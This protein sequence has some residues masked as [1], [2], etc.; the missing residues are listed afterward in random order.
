MAAGRLDFGIQTNLGNVA[1]PVLAQ[2]AATK[3]YVDTRGGGGAI[4][5]DNLAPI[6]INGNNITNNAIINSNTNTFFMTCT[7][8]AAAAAAYLNDPIHAGVTEYYFTGSTIRFNISSAA[9]ST[10]PNII[11]V[12]LNSFTDFSAAPVAAN[13]ALI[14]FSNAYTQINDIAL[15]T[16]LTGAVTNNAAG[17]PTLTINATGSAAITSPNSTITVGGT[18]TAP[19]IDVNIPAETTRVDNEIAARIGSAT[20]R[21]QM[22]NGTQ[23]LTVIISQIPGLPVTMTISTLTNAAT[24]LATLTSLGANARTLGSSQTGGATLLVESY[25]SATFQI[26]ANFPPATT[27]AQ[28]QNAF[29][30]VRSDSVWYGGPTTGQFTFQPAPKQAIAN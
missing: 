30:G 18:A 15:G 20:L 11:E 8:N 16:N 13:T 10:A 9:V 2:D 27:L 23:P 19:T 7:G 12:F 28:V 26:I 25:S 4:Y 21:T 29:L 6:S 14:D 24:I 22:S 5:F 1:D 17:R 3:N